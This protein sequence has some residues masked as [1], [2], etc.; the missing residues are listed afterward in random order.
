MNG[1]MMKGGVNE[2]WKDGWMLDGRHIL[3]NEWMNGRIDEYVWKAEW[4]NGWKMNVMFSFWFVL[5]GLQ[6]GV[7]ERMDERWME[8]ILMNEWMNGWMVKKFERSREWKDGKRDEKWM[9]EIY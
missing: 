5:I 7:N 9:E 4:M 8:E 3:M 6:E 1:W 2:R